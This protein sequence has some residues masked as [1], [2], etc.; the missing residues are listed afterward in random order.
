MMMK[1]YKKP[2]AEML[3]VQLAEYCELVN[4]SSYDFEG[5]AQGGEAGSTT[6]GIQSGS[7]VDDL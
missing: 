6:G 2:E 5:P 7:G 3:N 4:T 1:S